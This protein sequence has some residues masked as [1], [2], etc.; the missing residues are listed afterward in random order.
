[1]T[2]YV[3]GFLPVDHCL[4]KPKL[5]NLTDITR[6]TANVRYLTL[7]QES[8]ASHLLGLIRAYCLEN[9]RSHVP[10]HTL[11]CL[12]EAPALGWVGYDERYLVS[13]VGGL[14]LAIRE[15]LFSA[16]L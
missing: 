3:L 10:E 12:G 7:N 11:S 13:S 16:L 1:M 8:V 15:L 4:S 2:L 14:G 9:R 6:Q 5:I